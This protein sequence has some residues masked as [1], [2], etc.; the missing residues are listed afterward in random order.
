MP[1]KV[2]DIPGVGPTAF[3]DSMT[4]EQINAAASKVYADANPK[5]PSPD[6]THSWIDTATDWLPTVGGAVGGIVGGIGGTVAGVGVGG[7]PGAVGG[8]AVGG[9][10]GEAARQL[11]NRARGKDAPQTPADAATAIGAQGAIQGGA[12]AAGAWIGAGMKAVAPRVMQSAVKPTLAMMKE[13]PVGR[14]VST[15]LDQ[16]INVTEGGLQ[17][18]HALLTATNDEIRAA[19]N[20]SSARI[21]TGDVADRLTDLSQ[22]VAN[23]VNPTKDLNAVEAAGVEFRNHPRFAGP[24]GSVNLTTPVQTAQDLKVGTYRQLQGKYGEMSNASA[25]AQ[26][27]L[28]RGLKEEIAKEVPGIAELNSRDSDLLAA[29][30]AVGRRVA[31]SGNKDPIG[32]AWVTNHPTTFIAALL[33]KSPAVKSLLARGL[34]DNAA[35]AAKVSPQLIRTAVAALATH[36]SDESPSQ[37]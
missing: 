3:P 12:E 30:D 5:H 25:E 34:Y 11:V 18:L 37:E 22:R 4:P 16:G 2:I 23:Q 19:V 27:A 20:A 10:T 31:F 8:A 24:N 6:K 35:R 21:R 29:I 26:K 33:D 28:A 1:D 7:V 13:H 36:G 9:A 17:K 32:F 15:L 14:L